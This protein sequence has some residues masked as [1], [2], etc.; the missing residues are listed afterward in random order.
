[1]NGDTLNDTSQFNVIPQY[2]FYTFFYQNTFSVRTYLFGQTA[3]SSDGYYFLR[4]N[5]TIEMKY[6]I[7]YQRYE[8]EANIK[9]LN[10]R[11]LFLEYEDNGNTYF[12]K[13]YA[14]NKL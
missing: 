4:N 10:R 1:M 5:S 6:T 9:K 2:T 8:I 7:L 14:Y 11:E 12:L 3:T 13:F